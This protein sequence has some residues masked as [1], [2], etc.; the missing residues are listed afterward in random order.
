MTIRYFDVCAILIPGFG[1]LQEV[2]SHSLA[3]D[4]LM[5]AEFPHVVLSARQLE[6]H[7]GVPAMVYTVVPFPYYAPWMSNGLR[8][9]AHIKP[10]LEDLDL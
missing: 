7:H 3:A 10:E 1:P 5:P 9:I 8:R 4:L 6:D 2:G